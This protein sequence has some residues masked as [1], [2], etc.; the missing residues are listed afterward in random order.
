MVQKKSSP[1]RT[2]LRTLIRQSGYTQV[3]ICKELEIPKS[4]LAA[5][6]SGIYAIPHDLRV[7]LTCLF[8]CELEAL[9]CTPCDLELESRLVPLD[10]ALFSLP[11]HTW[12]ALRWQA[13]Q[14]VIQQWTGRAMYCTELQKLL[15][16][17]LNMFDYVRWLFPLQEE[18]HTSRREVLRALALLPLTALP[19]LPQ[20]ALS[21]KHPEELLPACA[22]SIAACWRLLNDSNAFTLI[23]QALSIYVPPLISLS[24]HSSLYRR[25]AASLAAQGCLLLDL[26]AY[27]EGDFARSFSYANQA[28]ELASVAY[29]PDLWGYSLLLAGGAANLLKQPQ[30]MLQRHQESVHDLAHFLQPLK[31]YALVQL[32]FSHAQ[33]GQVDQALYKLGEAQQAFPT[34]FGEVPV[35]LAADYDQTQLILFSGL[36]HLALADTDSDSAVEHGRQAA[37]ALSAIETLPQNVSVPSRLQCEMNNSRTQAAILIGDLDEAMHFFNESYQGALSLGS[38]KRW[39]ELRKNIQ[40]AQGRWGQEKRINEFASL[41]A[42]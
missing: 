3:E 27:H 25:S 34:V 6:C 26:V 15:D 1:F 7:K 4:T 30:T 40:Q 14:W 20:L 35:Y 23:G 17:E 36:T 8:G 39:E 41:V 16:L 13:I 32:A 21:R 22:G 11:S 19:D 38:Q 12:F 18:Y 29:D 10:S 33:N 42:H 31:S 5:Y 37:K 28:V 9:Q 2:N 24:R